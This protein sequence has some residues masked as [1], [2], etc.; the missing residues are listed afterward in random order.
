LSLPKF[1]H[2]AAMAFHRTDLFLVA[3]ATVELRPTF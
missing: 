1:Q 3:A 2:E